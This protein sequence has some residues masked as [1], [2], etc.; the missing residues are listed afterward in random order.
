[1]SLFNA[2]VIID[3]IIGVNLEL[4]LYRLPA[5]KKT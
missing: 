4:K 3:I 1:L 5:L 2:K